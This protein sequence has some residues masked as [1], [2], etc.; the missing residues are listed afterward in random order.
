[1]TDVL[2]RLSTALADRYTIERELG[3]LARADV[4]RIIGRDARPSYDSAAAA[5]ERRLRVRPDEGWDH[6]GLGVAYRGLGRR[7]D[8]IREGQRALELLV[9]RDFYEGPRLHGMLAE[10]YRTFGDRE[11]AAEAFERFVRAMPGNRPAARH[12]PQ[13]ADLRALPRIRALLGS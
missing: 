2:A 1:V 7:D 6:G 10:T 13:Y 3:Y 4:F 8:A 9:G 11:A 5:Y 12:D